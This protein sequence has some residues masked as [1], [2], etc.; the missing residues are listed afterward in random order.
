[1]S[2]KSNWQVIA[3]VAWASPALR[4]RQT[5]DA[6][7]LIATAVL[8]SRFNL[9]EKLGRFFGHWSPKA[10]AAFSGHDVIVVKLK[11]EFLWYSHPNTDDFFCVRKGSLPIKLRDGDVHL[12]PG[13]LYVVPKGRGGAVR[14]RRGSA[15]AYRAGWHAQHLGCIHR[16]HK[17]VDLIGSIAFPGRLPQALLLARNLSNCN[18]DCSII[19]SEI[20]DIILRKRR[21]NLPSRQKWRRTLR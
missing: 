13:D 6:L 19:G 3:Y 21:R 5:A 20:F 16:C 10:V 11:G 2:A 8:D 4:A 9:E 17:R 7:G 18:F 14:R 12:G 15:S 1:V